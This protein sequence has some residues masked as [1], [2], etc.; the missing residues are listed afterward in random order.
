MTLNS[1]IFLASYIALFLASVVVMLWWHRKQRKRRLPFGDDMLLLRAPGE[2]Q[3][4]LVRKFEEDM[5]ERMVWAAFAPVVVASLCLMATTQLPPGIKPAGLVVSLGAFLITFYSSA[6]WFFNRM[7]ENGHRY[8]GYF[9]ERL[10]AEQLE[11]LK[12]RGWRIFHD[13]PAVRNGHTFNLDH[14]AVGP[15]GVFVIETKTFRKGLGEGDHKVF[16][17][18]RDLT[19]PWGVDDDGLAQAESNAVWLADRLKTET[20]ERV[21]VIY[22]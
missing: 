9:G 5:F 10:V 12:L 11:P 1:G 6:R 21:H 14:V 17:S 8:L 4:N 2:S 20:G 3:L 15:A 18:G 7:V 19:W 16:F 22:G 13:V